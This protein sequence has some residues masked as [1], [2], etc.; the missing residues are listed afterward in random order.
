MDLS[1][2][3]TWALVALAAGVIPILLRLAMYLLAPVEREVGRALAGPVRDM[4]SVA[5]DLWQTY[6]VLL[7]QLLR[8]VWKALVTDCSEFARSRAARRLAKLASKRVRPRRAGPRASRV[9]DRL[10][11]A[12]LLRLPAELRERY[13]EEWAD[14]RSHKVGWRLLWWAFW[15]RATA[16]RTARE[17]RHARL[18][19]GGG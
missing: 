4:L 14:H 5:R 1:G 10:L 3:E 12:A 11:A 16:A 17:Y 18:P 15:L 19:R 6:D 8:T 2:V 7:K 9:V 13:A